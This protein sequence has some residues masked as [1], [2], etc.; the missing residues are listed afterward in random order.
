MDHH[1]MDT[2]FRFAMALKRQE[3]VP[4]QFSAIIRSAL[5]GQGLLDTPG[6]AGKL[7]KPE[8]LAVYCLLFLLRPPR[9]RSHN[10]PVN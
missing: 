4:V 1:G 8:T 2:K 5:G 7:L 10:A 9:V 3:V 6:M